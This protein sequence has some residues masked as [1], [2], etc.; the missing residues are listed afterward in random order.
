MPFAAHYR[1][2]VIVSHIKST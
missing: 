1:V 2:V